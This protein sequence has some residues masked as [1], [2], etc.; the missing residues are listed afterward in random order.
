MEIILLKDVPGLGFKDEILNVKNGY[1]RNFLI[2]NGLALVCNTSN[3]CGNI[4]SSTIKSF[5]LL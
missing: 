5:F 1:G 2:P 4:L 3:V